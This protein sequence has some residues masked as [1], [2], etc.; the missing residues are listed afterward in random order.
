LG[1]FGLQYEYHL[2][3]NKSITADIAV[4]RINIDAN[5]TITDQGGLN[6]GVISA[7]QF[8]PSFRFYSA[9]KD[10]PRGFYFAPGIR[11]TRTTYNTTID[12]LSNQFDDI[13]LSFRYPTIGINLDLGAQWLIEDRVSIDWNFLGIGFQTGRPSVVL[14][15]LTES[16]LQQLADELTEEATD[17]ATGP[18]FEAE[19]NRVRLTSNLPLPFLRSRIAIG[20][21]F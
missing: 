7:F 20:V 14:P 15:D 21:V 16:E 5:S 2:G 6:E 9:K 11:F 1:K 13:E 12:D 19:G 8:N 10:G 17:V 3:E 4:R 18:V